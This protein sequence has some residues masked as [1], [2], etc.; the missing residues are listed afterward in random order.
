[1]KHVRINICRIIWPIALC[2]WG[3]DASAQSAFVQKAAKSVFTLTTFKSDG[4]L[5]ASSHGVFVGNNGEAVS[6]WAPFVGADSAVVIDA[7]GNKMPVDV[8][9]GTNEIYDICKF[10]VK[11]KTV[12]A[13]IA[14]AAAPANSKAWL[15]GYS[16]QK[17][18]IIP[19]S[20]LSIEKFMDRYNYYIFSGT[21]PAN[22]V[23]CPFVNQNGEVIGLLQQ[24][25]ASPGVHAID[26]RFA[27]NF[28]V[29][30]G[31]DVSNKVIQQTGIRLEMPRKEDQAL[32]LLVM[33]SQGNPKQY[34]QYANDFIRLFPTSVDG[35]RALAQIEVGAGKLQAAN[36]IMQTAIAKANK[37]D[38]AH[39]ELAKIMYQEQIYRRDSTFTL[40]NL[41]T[42]LDQSQKAYAINPQPV[43]RHQQ[44]QIIFAKGDYNQALNIFTELTKT[45]LR[46]SELYFEIAQCKTQLK[47]PHEEIIELLDSAVTVCP[48]PL[49]NISAPYF[50]ARGTAHDEAGEYRKALADYNQY[51]SL[52]YGRADYGFY[53]TRYKCELN[54]RQY[55]QALNDI[56]HAALLNPQDPTYLAELSALQLRVNHYDDAI[57]TA[58]MCMQV[59]PNY[60]DP[61]IIKGIAL[62]QKGNK[63][64]GRQLFQKAKELGDTRAQGYLDNYK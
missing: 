50:L 8:M 60:T 38:E 28:K 26:V 4:S 32:I 51:D 43:Y 41:D 48:K 45:P 63:K 9:I 57:T 3:I 29:E 6:V 5:V 1:M 2:L 18:E 16:L 19:M 10:R 56:A 21:V 25:A 59:A 62:I 47:A 12:P 34:R 14:A 42:A 40:W 44:A 20:I 58:D 46:N 22:A 11:G 55:Q 53:Y 15:L 13:K 27:N 52:M 35:Y 49:T 24:S 33:A 17:P 31:L 23:S 37:K 7:A 64:E 54:L 30:N 61:Y 36:D 39:S